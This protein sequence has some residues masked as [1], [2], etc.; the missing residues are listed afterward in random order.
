[1]VLAAGGSTRL[2]RP[3]QLLELRGEP[4]V[5]RAARIAAEAGYDPVVVVL[6]AEAEAVA[7]ALG[8]P[9]HA[10]ANPRWGSGA[11]SSVRA[12]LEALQALR[13]GVEGVLLLAC[14]QPLLEP[15]HLAA[16]AAALGPG[17]AIAASRYA[18]TLGVPALFARELFGELL[19]LAGERG[20]RGVVARDPRR[21]A[22]V[23]LPEAARDVDTEEDWAALPGRG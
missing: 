10:V 12:G 14:D 19:A 2:G 9:W 22:A 16:L 5:R 13:P 21:V 18:G 20:A 15:R 1:V 6:G 23:D 11:A 4:L 3:K 7:G 17:R 8:P